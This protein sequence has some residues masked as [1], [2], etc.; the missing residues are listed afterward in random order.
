MKK[1]VI[2]TVL[3][4][5]CFPSLA[6][7]DG[8]ERNNDIVTNTASNLMWQDDMDAVYNRDTLENAQTLCKTL[9]TGGFKDWRLPTYD[10]LIAIVDYSRHDPAINP[11]FQNNGTDFYW[12]SSQYGADPD[13]IW[14]VRFSDGSTNKSY[15]T[16]ENYVRCVRNK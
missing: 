1:S 13:S 16:Y 10:E 15:K 2:Y 12:T 4:L 8:W 14:V 7:S 9:Q 5:A 11:A 6:M 3:A